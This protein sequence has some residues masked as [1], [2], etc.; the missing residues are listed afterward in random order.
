MSDHR[1]SRGENL[2]T[3]K[4]VKVGR[5][6]FEPLVYN[7]GRSVWAISYNPA[8]VRINKI[9]HRKLTACHLALNY[10][11]I[12]YISITFSLRCR[13]RQLIKS[14]FFLAVTSCYNLV[15]TSASNLL[16]IQH[17]MLK[18]NLSSLHLVFSLAM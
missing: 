12:T 14:I 16:L 18:I 6:L 9:K 8:R 3:V 7:T 11:L 5:R 2:T 10:G 15:I 4:K 17:N 1:F 13:T